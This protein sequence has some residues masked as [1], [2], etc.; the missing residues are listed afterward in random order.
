MS[1]IIGSEAKKQFRQWKS[2]MRKGFLKTFGIYLTVNI[3]MT[4]GYILFNSLTPA[5]SVTLDLNP[6]LATE[7]APL[8]TLAVVILPITLLL[9]DMGFRWMPW[10]LITQTFRLNSLEVVPAFDEEK[11]KSWA[12]VEKRK[13]RLWLYRNYRSVYLVSAIIMHCAFHYFNVA[14][15]S[16]QGFFVY[17]FVQAT[18]GGMLARIFLRYGFWESYTIH[19]SYDLLLIGFVL[20]SSLSQI[21]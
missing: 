14:T 5:T 4:L 17:G 19:L 3:L 20:L 18:I 10:I 2:F 8:F 1:D 7:T 6:E 12:Y 11:K 15:A 21:F 13:W 16:S 9:E